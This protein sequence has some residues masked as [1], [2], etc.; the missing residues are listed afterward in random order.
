MAGQR[1]SNPF[2]RL[3]LRAKL[4]VLL[5]F[6]AL[7]PVSVVSW[8]AVSV[9]LGNLDRGL[10][11]ET[12]RQLQVGLSLV[13]QY[14]ERV[15]ADAARLAHSGELSAAIAGHG[16]GGSTDATASDTRAATHSS[17]GRPTDRVSR[18]LERVSAYVPRSLVQVFDRDGHPLA[19]S[20]DRNVTSPIAS[21]RVASDSQLVVSGLLFQT[22]LTI[23]PVARVLVVRA[24]APIKDPSDNLLGV[25]VVSAPLDKSFVDKIKRD[26]GTHVLIFAARRPQRGE[27]VLRPVSHPVLVRGSS[28]YS[29]PEQPGDRAIGDARAARPQPPAA[30]HPPISTLLDKRDQRETD[31]LLPADV[32]FGARTHALMRKT[33]QIFGHEYEVGYTSLVDL[34]RDMVGVFAVAVDRAPL[35]QATS[36]ATRSLV[37][38]AVGALV[39]ALALAGFLTRRLTRPLARLHRGAL[40]VARGDLDQRIELS[41]GDEIGDLAVAFSHMTEALRENQE[42]LAARMREIVAIHDAGRAVSSVIDL[43]EVLHTIVDSVARVFDVGVCVLWLVQERAASSPGSG[44]ESGLSSGATTVRLEI[45]AARILRNLTAHAAPGDGAE[46]QTCSRHRWVSC[47]AE[48]RQGKKPLCTATESLA[49]IASEVAEQRVTVRVD[50]V[51]DDPVYR[52]AALAAGVTG[53]LMAT[54]LERKGSV[55]GVLVVGRT[56]QVELFSEADSNL[57][58]TFADQAA[59]AIENARLYEEVRGFNEE[60]EAMVKVRTAELTETNAELGR[61]ITELGET[62]AQLILSERMAGLGLLVAGMAHEINS[63]SAAI[64]G[65]VNALADNVARLRVRWQELTRLPFDSAQLTA[66]NDLVTARA[67][68]LAAEPMRSAVT[69]RRTARAFTGRFDRVAISQSDRK[70]VAHKMAE[71]GA[72]D[73]LVERCIELAATLPAAQIE[74]GTQGLAG[75]LSDSVFLH[76]SALTIRKSIQR[77]QRI[78]GALKT[79]SHLDQ[80]ANLVQSDLHEGIENTLVIL[81]YV[82]RD[83]TIVRNFG[84]LPTVPAFVDELNQ[85]WT[86]LIHNAVQA[87]EGQGQITI[88]TGRRGS[89]VFVRII[90]DGPGIA[91]AVLPRIFEPFFTT[92]PKGEG[93]GL[94]LGIVRQIVDKHDGEVT[95]DSRPGRTCFEVR[96]PLGRQGVSDQPWCDSPAPDR[97]VCRQTPRRSPAHQAPRA[98]E[99]GAP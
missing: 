57:L 50:R 56:R 42:R 13:K 24:A 26:L 22:P 79:Y 89:G 58:A 67:P 99:E 76:R 39:F 66:F 75:Y 17:P 36:A 1:I 74:R 65:S 19:E 98:V 92:K 8:L 16:T 63:P 43:S 73:D 40:A 32:A 9:V 7:L 70:L 82:L 84:D 3:R 83:I 2:A 59:A 97:V 68:E 27:R 86:N 93:T 34:E 62:Q 23:E 14:G 37:L 5:S 30:V 78:V 61:T 69:V 12:E 38:G 54:P 6:A 88:E 33:Q 49:L 96:L 28:L 52:D 18:V 15:Q 77:I 20:I 85:V 10:R 48:P 87:V 41:E 46:S 90:D 47:A 11:D 80:E 94:G 21:L 29:R 71:C 72:T 25:V 91:E 44:S 60:L 4:A 53:S 64:A 45:G 81:D 55:V 51:A 35:V 31:I 95:C